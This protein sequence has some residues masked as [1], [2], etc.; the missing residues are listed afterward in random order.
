MKTWRFPSLICPHSGAVTFVELMLFQWK[1]MK[2]TKRLFP[3]H[4]RSIFSS[5]VLH[6]HCLM[7]VFQKNFA[8]STATEL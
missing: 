4:K 7:F 5:S 2:D 3:T 1:K 8:V 6:N